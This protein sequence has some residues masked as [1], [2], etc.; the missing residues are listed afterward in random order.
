MKQGKVTPSLIRG[1]IN[2][3]ATLESD[4]TNVEQEKAEI[5]TACKLHNITT[6]D[7]NRV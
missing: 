2:L 1:M 7:I 3:V 6:E 4:G 5:A